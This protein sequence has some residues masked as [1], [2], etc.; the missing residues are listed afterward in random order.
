MQKKLIR[1]TEGDLHRIIKESVNRILKESYFD[2]P[3]NR[4]MKKQLKNAYKM[5]PNY[6]RTF[7][8]NLNKNVLGDEGNAIDTYLT[9]QNQKWD[10]NNNHITPL[11]KKDEIDAAWDDAPY[12]SKDGLDFPDEGNDANYN[13]Y[14]FW[15]KNQRKH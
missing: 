5:P 11:A 13:V 1:L 2:S 15:K 7:N 10:V 12:F 4:E 9:K 6:D 14:D 3:Y 8:K